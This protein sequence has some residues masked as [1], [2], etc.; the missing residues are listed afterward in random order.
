MAKKIL[1][2]GGPTDESIDEVMR[3][4]NMSTGKF[5]MNLAKKFQAEGWELC[6]I[7]NE[8]ID[9]SS[10][11]EKTRVVK[12][13][14][15]ADMD[16]AI[17]AE[18][19]WKPDVILHLSAVGDYKTDFVFSMADLAE[20]IFTRIEDIEGPQEIYDILMNPEC[21][22]DRGTKLTSNQIDLTVKLDLTAKI[23]AGLRETFPDSLIVG[24][25]LLE[26]VSKEAL[27]EA[28]SLLCIKNDVDYILANDLADLRK[29]D[30]TR[31]L[32]DKTGYLGLKLEDIDSIYRFIVKEVD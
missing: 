26:G 29:G 31:Y 20:E 17:K 19:N 13:L 15:A 3:I 28:A 9:S 16:A 8:K 25:K 11:S 14:S 12:V 22:L 2:T 4:T 24:A 21:K 30:P 1:I 5:S 32:V 27:Y 23:I 10:L 18:K 7:I 6:L